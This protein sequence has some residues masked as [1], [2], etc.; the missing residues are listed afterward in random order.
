MLLL[1]AAVGV[2]A[3][4]AVLVSGMA[5]SILEDGRVWRTGTVSEH[6]EVQGTQTTSRFIFRNYD[7]QVSFA[8]AS[9]EVRSATVSY[10]MLF[11]SLDVDAPLEVRFDPAAPGRVALSWA[12][13]VLVARWLQVLFVGAVMVLGFGGFLGWAGHKALQRFRDVRAAAARPELQL[14]GVLAY[15]GEVEHSF[16]AKWNTRSGHVEQSER[17]RRWPGFTSP[18][19]WDG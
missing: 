6:A 2:A 11:G 10:G 15:S 13:D 1:L 14:L 4:S 12:Q 5:A 8:D 3:G 16:R 7:L 17:Q 18:P 19:S 9:G